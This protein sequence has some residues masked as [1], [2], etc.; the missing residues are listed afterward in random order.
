MNCNI[1]NK[2]V[3]LVPSATQRAIK[4]GGTASYYT[5]LFPVHSACALKKREE[6]VFKL[7]KNKKIDIVIH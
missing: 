5:R 7:M 3:V 1:C 6:E 2:P 4:Y